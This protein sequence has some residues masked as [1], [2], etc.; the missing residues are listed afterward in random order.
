[1]HPVAGVGGSHAIE[2][3]AVLTNILAETLQKE[4][5]PSDA[6][7]NEVFQKFQSGRNDRATQS[8]KEAHQMQKM[9]ILENRVLRFIQLVVTP[10]LSAG[11][12]MNQVTAQ[13]SP[14]PRLNALPVPMRQDRWGYNDEVRLKPRQRTPRQTL[15]FILLLVCAM[16]VS[17]FVLPLDTVS[18]I[19]SVGPLLHEDTQIRSTV[20][21]L[22]L[23]VI[24]TI[25][26]YRVGAVMTPLIR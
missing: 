20:L 5:C 10:R 1:M 13:F 24:W 15:L 3:A 2:S 14:A 26:S 7:V 8:Y 11:F 19:S 12:I 22:A 9:H 18:N 4:P 23:T 17:R 6:S 21:R 16:I 25:E